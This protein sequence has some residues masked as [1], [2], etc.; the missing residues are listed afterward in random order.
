MTRR[1]RG[2]CLAT[3][4]LPITPDDLANA[5]AQA[6]PAAYLVPPRTL[7]HV[8]KRDR[9]LMVLSRHALRPTTYVLPGSALAS[10]LS[11]GDIPGAAARGPWPET[12]YLLERPEGD[13]LRETTATVLLQ[14]AWRRLFR[15]RIQEALRQRIA[16]GTL[17]PAALDQRIAAIGRVTFEEAKLVFR[18]DG[19]LLFPGTDGEAY[20]LFAAYF[21]ELCQFAP[22]LLHSTFPG[23]AD[24]RAISA[25]FAEDVDAAAVVAATRPPGALEPEPLEK[26]AATDDDEEED[27]ESAEPVDEA[28]EAADVLSGLAEM[29]DSDAPVAVRARHALMRGNLVRAALLWTQA[30]DQTA[31]HP[32][33]AIEASER[34]RAAA[35]DVIRKLAERLQVVLGRPQNEVPVWTECLTSM[36]RRGAKGFWTPEARLLYDLQRVCLDHD[37]EIYRLDTLGWLFSFGRKPLQTPLPELREVS[38]SNRLRAAVER[39][40]KL[41]LKRDERAQLETLLRPAV[42]QAE[43]ALRERFRPR[44]EAALRE[45]W[46]V[47]AN[48]PEKVAHAKLVEELLDQVVRHGYLSLGDLRDF[49][50]RGDLKLADLK[51]PVQVWQGGPLLE[52]DQALAQS[53]VGVHRR[54]EIY[55]R[56]LQRISM[57]AFGTAFGRWLTRYVVLPFGGAYVALEGLQHIIGL[58]GVH[59]ELTEWW[60]L[61]PLALL[62]LGTLNVA[63]FRSMVVA[64]AKWIGRGLGHLLSLPGRLID[65]PLLARLVHSDGAMLVWLWLLKPGLVAGSAWLLARLY[66]AESYQAHWIAAVAFLAALVVLNTKL[67][68]QIEESASEALVSG[69]RGLIYDLVPGLFR[70]V[71]ASFQ[72]VLE[73]VERLLYAVDEALR[74]RAGQSRGS[75]VLKAMAAPV[76]AAAAYGARVVA[77]VLVEPQVNPIKHFPVVT[78][79]HKIFLPMAPKLVPPDPDTGQGVRHVPGHVHDHGP[80]RHVWISGLGAPVE[81]A[82]VRGEPARSVAAGDGGEP[83]RDGRPFAPPW[84]SF[85]NAAEGVCA[86]ASGAAS[87]LDRSGAGA[88]GEG[89]VQAA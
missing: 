3:R 55:L 64:T 37:R 36:L 86:A 26:A 67:G 88:G 52:T 8:I 21:L 13:E 81:L 1:R 71:M 70:L 80:A 56:F 54:G 53:M 5:V 76:W 42:R 48:V 9:G 29:V 32:E 35:R 22:R 69:W 50:S 15:A 65:N 73:W 59:V 30:A 57:S 17:D 44:I 83:R 16:V 46:V 74:F 23:I 40:P 47:P 51:S 39:L 61:L 68:R 25:V 79:S 84:V 82:V 43:A 19:W 77:N 60:I 27:E 11:P 85:G 14:I 31:A 75:L 38:V 2:A 72:Q 28:A 41:R 66:E 4:S 78:V 18:Q 89:G 20:S 12:V 6:E 62:I 87:G 33:T 63:L 49:S 58:S 24:Y 7:R 34:D 10:I 45:H